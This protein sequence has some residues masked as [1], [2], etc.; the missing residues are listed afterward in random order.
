MEP[1]PIDK[2]P[3]RL[4][5]ELEPGPYFVLPDEAALRQ[6]AGRLKGDRVLHSRVGFNLDIAHWRLAKVPVPSD[7]DT[8]LKERVVHAH[9][10]G[11]HR[12]AHFGDIPPLD[13]NA[14]SDFDPWLDLLE[15]IAL[16]TQAREASPG[17]S[18]YV[19]L[20]AE[21]AKN[22]EIVQQSVRQ[23]VALL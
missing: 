18:G 22:V 15:G 23:L 12:R 6:I 2:Y 3:V 5:L 11:H 17:F 9:L 21:A 16:S 4:A 20:E 10:S 19:S 7:S 14:A 8:T 1:L 13:L